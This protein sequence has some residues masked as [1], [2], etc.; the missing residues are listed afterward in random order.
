MSCELDVH[1]LLSVSLVQDVR[2]DHLRNIVGPCLLLQVGRSPRGTASISFPS[3]TS[4]SYSTTN[5]TRGWEVCLVCAGYSS[6]HSMI[7][8]ETFFSESKTERWIPFI[9][10]SES[11][12]TIP[13]P[14]SMD[15]MPTSTVLIPRF[16]EKVRLHRTLY[17]RTKQEFI[18][19]C[20]SSPFLRRDF[21]LQGRRL[22]H[23]VGWDSS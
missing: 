2:V 11:T 6:R 17:V 20:F 10:R 14:L 13:E 19:I 23:S 12:T 9:V 3:S 18:C 16:S 7:E 8:G 22:L 21:K 4:N 1:G 15:A 5:S